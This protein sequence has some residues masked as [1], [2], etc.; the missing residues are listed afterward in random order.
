LLPADRPIGPLLIH[1]GVTSGRLARAYRREARRAYR[2]FPW[3]V[4]LTNEQRDWFRVHGR[5]LAEVLLGYL[6]EAALEGAQE[7]LTEATSEA[8]AYG[9]MAAGMGISLSQTV[10]GFLQF[11][12]PFLHELGLF[13]GRRGLD[14]TTTTEL[15]ESAERAMDRLLM[16]TL[17]AHSIE[18]GA[19]RLPPEPDAE[20]LR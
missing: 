18:R 6:E 16:A 13:A 20:G 3:L 15:M 8:A 14:A 7:S 17:S 19:R 10:E 9:R 12:R 1:S 4:T 11:R 2:Q 5:R